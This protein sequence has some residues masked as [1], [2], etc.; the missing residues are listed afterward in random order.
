MLAISHAA[1]AI[2]DRFFHPCR[3]PMRARR[4][5]TNLALVDWF[6]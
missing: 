5:L 6:T 1:T 2:P 4:S 3:I